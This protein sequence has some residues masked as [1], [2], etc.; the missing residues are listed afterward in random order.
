MT[1]QVPLVLVQHSRTKY[2]EIRHH[3]LR[4]CAQK[5]DISLEFVRIEYQLAEI[6]T[7]PFNEE[8]FVDIRMQLGV[9]TL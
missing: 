5:G 9:I 7:K 2:L 8:Q 4:V 1:T 6:L 3:F